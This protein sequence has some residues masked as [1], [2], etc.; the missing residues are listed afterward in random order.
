M[1]GPDGANEGSRWEATWRG[2]PTGPST[3]MSRAPAG[4]MKPAFA[5]ISCAPLGRANTSM[6]SGGCAWFHQASHRLPS[7]A[8]PARGVRRQPFH[9]KKSEDQGWNGHCRWCCL[10]GVGGRKADAKWRDGTA[11]ALVVSGMNEVVHG[12]VER[13]EPGMGRVSG[14]RGPWMIARSFLALLT[15]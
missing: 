12:N 14:V 15:C 9:R 8:P 6:R 4:R 5:C 11:V 3:K 2:A 1:C 10:R 7:S 13:L